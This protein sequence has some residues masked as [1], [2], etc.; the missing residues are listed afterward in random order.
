WAVWGAGAEV[1]APMRRRRQERRATRLPRR[2]SHGQTGRAL[3]TRRPPGGSM[4]GATRRSKAPDRTEGRG[5]RLAKPLPGTWDAATFR[6]QPT[7]T[8]AAPALQSPDVPNARFGMTVR[9][10]IAV[11][12]GSA[13]LTLLVGI[14]A[15]A[16]VSR[17]REAIAAVDHVYAV[18]GHLDGT[19]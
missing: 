13:V 7:A 18:I 1:A 15:L 6:A 3:G 4:G 5:M 8:T 10:K 9:Q 12:L 16:A 2:G 19:L 14:A 11:S 17:L